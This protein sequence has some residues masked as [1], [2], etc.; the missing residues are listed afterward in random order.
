MNENIELTKDDSVKDDSVKD[1]S[2]KDEYVKEQQIYN[3]EL[4]C[5]DSKSFFW[6]ICDLDIKDL[7]EM[8]T[9]E[10]PE[11][12]V[13]R[14][15]INNVN[16]ILT[17]IHINVRYFKYRYNSYSEQE[18]KPN[19]YNKIKRIMDMP[20]KTLQENLDN[21]FNKDFTPKV[22][23]H[24]QIKFRYKP[25]FIK[26]VKRDY[27]RNKKNGVTDAVSKLSMHTNTTEELEP[28]APTEE[29]EPIHLLSLCNNGIGPIVVV[30]NFLTIFDVS[31]RCS[32]L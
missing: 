21:D 11:H 23:R 9:C 14:L 15:T 24:T 32:L 13:T 12:I 19:Y 3:G 30:I 18:I 17:L 29:V 31:A 22:G 7:I 5:S 25:E 20:A 28:P 27:D 8:I 26:A 6:T 10:L 2:V 4:I 16:D 1:E